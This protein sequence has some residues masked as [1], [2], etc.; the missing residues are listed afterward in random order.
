MERCAG[1]AKH[2]IWEIGTSKHNTGVHISAAGPFMG[3]LFRQ[4]VW[5]DDEK[6]ILL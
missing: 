2:H 3:N 5:S 1:Q 6:T 4:K